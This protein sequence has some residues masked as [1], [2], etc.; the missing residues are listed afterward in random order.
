M[1]GCWVRTPLKNLRP[2]SQHKHTSL[3]T[4]VGEYQAFPFLGSKRS[5]VTL[6]VTLERR[7]CCRVV[8]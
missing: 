8:L 7:C 2:A 3:A 4:S 5:F 1:G 6:V